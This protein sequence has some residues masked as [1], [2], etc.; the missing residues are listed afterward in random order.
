M[1]SIL[2]AMD[3]SKSSKSVLNV[4]VALARICGAKV[5]GLYVEDAMRLLEWQPIELIG[6]A[7]GVTSGIPHSR[8]T[9]EQVEV[10][11]QFIAEGNRLEKS[12]K[13]ECKKF[14]VNYQF[15][16]KRG[17]V[18]EIVEQMARTVDMIVV[19][20]RGKTYPESSKEP[21][22]ITEDL[23]RVT[24]RPVLVVPEN[25][26]VNNKILIAYDGSQNSQRALSVGASFAK[27]L[28]F[29]VQ[30]I[31]VANDIDIAQKSL[32]EGKEFLAPY[33]L[34]A[35]YITDFGAAMPWIAIAKQ[36]KIFAPGL[37]VIGAFG[38]NKLMELIFG[39]TTK[40]VL[41]EATCPVL[42]CR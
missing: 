25:A 18:H 15:F 34:N 20:R 3:E 23:L 12:F 36:I 24:T 19:G 35:T 21:G 9:L 32:D 40:Q 8:P 37:I 30:I 38:T 28:N 5:K 39:S 11:K 22:P 26:K 1:K 27:L 17:K 13:E 6:A 10:E 2:I 41:M 42:L 16:T 29:E 4:G 31:S 33:E 14:A 7:V